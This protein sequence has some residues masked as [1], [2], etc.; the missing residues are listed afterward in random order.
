MR[1][2]LLY[3]SFL[4]VFIPSL[5][6]ATDYYVRPAGGSYGSGNG[7]SYA[8]A[9]SGFSNI[10]WTTVNNGNGILYIDGSNIE[11]LTIGASGE[12]GTPIYI[13]GYS[14]S[15]SVNGIYMSN[16]TYVTIDGI[17]SENYAGS[18]EGIV[19]N[20]SSSNITIK[21][22]IVQ[23][24]R[25]GG[26]AHYTTNNFATNIIIDNTIVRNNGS[27]TDINSGIFFKGHDIIIRYCT[28]YNNGYGDDAVGYSHGIYID[29]GTTSAEIYNNTIYS[30]PKG[31]G[32]QSKANSNIYN[33]KI[34]GNRN[35]GI[36]GGENGTYAIVQNIHHNS[37]YNNNDA[38]I[39]L[40]SK[41]S[42]NFDANI[43][44]NSTYKNG[45]GGT[46]SWYAEL[47]V[48]ENMTSLKIN[49]NIFF[50]NTDDSTVELATQ[51][52]MVANYNIHYGPSG[53]PIRYGGSIRAWSYWVTTLGMDA[54]GYNTDPKYINP[55]SDMALQ[56]WFSRYKYQ[57]G[58]VCFRW[59][60]APHL[61]PP[62]VLLLHP[63]TS[64][65]F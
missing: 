8:N 31:N 27:T 26:I 3:L 2:V 61:H 40:Y 51:S 30:N 45:V 11:T 7:T 52:N 1:K 23:N 47:Y 57:C 19:I 25:R 34:Y 37:L 41:G 5:A 49:N 39:S 12:S 43:Y 44:N 9:W 63:T 36:H 32:I 21:N 59:S 35:A 65:V 62:N 6:G 20:D 56:S 17:T 42:G 55:P 33:N 29:Q 16:K 38:A 14:S 60:P 24:N 54:S 10:N 13:K 28:V 15:A 64:K 18:I 50:A 4:S 58:C 46:G 53:N 22:C 48:Q